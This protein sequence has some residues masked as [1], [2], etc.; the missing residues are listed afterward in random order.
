MAWPAVHVGPGAASGAPPSFFL[1]EHHERVTVLID[2]FGSVESYGTG[3]ARFCDEVGGHL[4]VAGPGISFLEVCRAVA[5]GAADDVADGIRR[6][7]RGDLDAPVSVRVTRHSPDTWR[8]FDV[9]IAGRRDDGGGHGGA[10]VSLLV[11]ALGAGHDRRAPPA[12]GP[13]VRGG[14]PGAGRRRDP[15]RPLRTAG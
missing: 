4:P 15:G 13:H 5:G 6:A 3:W 7:L 11:G 8:W 14:R 1:H 12:G 9:R 2:R 10:A